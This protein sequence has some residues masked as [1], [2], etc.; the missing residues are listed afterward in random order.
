MT[1]IEKA[2]DKLFSEGCTC[3]LCKDDIVYTSNC[4]GVKPLVYWYYSK[5]DCNGFSAADKVVGRATAFLY[6]LLGVKSVFAGVISRS[7]LDLLILYGVDVQYKIL[8][9]HIVNRQGNGICPFEETVIGIEDKY[10]AYKA[11]LMKMKDMN[12][13]L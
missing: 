6:I 8:A 12:I 7:A 3:V 9:E 4:R 11:I 1:D 5:I 13:E 10:E 2:K